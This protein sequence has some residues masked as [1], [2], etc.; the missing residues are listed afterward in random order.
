VVI[1]LG[2]GEFTL[3]NSVQR[4]NVGVWQLK[5]VVQLPQVYK[6]N[7]WDTEGLPAN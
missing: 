3:S 2:W 1:E 5:Q 6:K 7:L 4:A